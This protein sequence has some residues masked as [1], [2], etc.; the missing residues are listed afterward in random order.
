MLLFPPSLH[1]V[2]QRFTLQSYNIFCIHANKYVYLTL[3]FMWK[4]GKISL[5]LFCTQKE[6]ADRKKDQAEYKLRGGERLE[7]RG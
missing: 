3:I 7:V 2:S 4:C 5:I 6:Q 1:K